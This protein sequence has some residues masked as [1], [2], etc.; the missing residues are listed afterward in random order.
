[1]NTERFENLVLA[2]CQKV[3]AEHLATTKLNKLIWLIDKT[4]FLELGKSITGATYLRK[5]NG[6]VPKDNKDIFALMRDNKMC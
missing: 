2:I 3:P 6:P 4:A 1:M 5:M